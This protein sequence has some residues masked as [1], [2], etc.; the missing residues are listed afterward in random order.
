MGG[1]LAEECELCG[2]AMSEVYV[3]SIENT[4]MR[5]CVSCSKGKKILYKEVEAK[6]AQSKPAMH[7]SVQR[8]EEMELVENYGTVMHKARDEMQ[9]PLKVLAEMINEKESLL[10][11]IEN[12]KTKPSV[13]LTKKLEKA[14]HVKLTQHESLES[15]ARARGSSDR[16]TIGDFIKK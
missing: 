9:I 10:L 15:N 14:L 12:E 4:D 7:K 13:E 1:E 8:E 11:R 2:R 6:K 5:V 3:V 16:A